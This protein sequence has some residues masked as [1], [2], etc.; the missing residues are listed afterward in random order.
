MV[1]NGRENV[2]ST[3]SLAIH[4]LLFFSPIIKGELYPY[5]IENGD[6]KVALDEWK[7]GSQKID[8][9]TSLRLL[10]DGRL[11][12]VWVSIVVDL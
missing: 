8:L 1:S 11:S 5:G 12:S 6:T 10:G 3:L 4:I 7:L 2:S 9:T